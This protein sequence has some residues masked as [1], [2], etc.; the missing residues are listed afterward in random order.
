MN[1]RPFA[2]G[3]VLVLLQAIAHA[4][5]PSSVDP[6]RVCVT[7]GEISSQ[8][9]KEFLISSSTSRAV[10]KKSNGNFN[11]L[12]FVYLGPTPI[13][14][15]LASGRIARQLGLSLRVRDTC[16]L[17]YVM[18]STEPDAGIEISSKSN[19]GKSTH[20]Q[21][22]VKGYKVIYNSKPGDIAAIRVGESRRLEASMD[23]RVLTVKIDGREV[24]QGDVG[25]E[26]GKTSGYSG[27]RTDNVQMRFRWLTSTPSEAGGD[28]KPWPSAMHCT[29][30]LSRGSAGS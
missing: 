4:Q 12:E 1:F 9:G 14:T 23:G 21:C 11:A 17:I 26:A 22:G 6:G 19:P 3:F 15:P 7:N 28:S 25:A 10:A 2:A 13:E 30:V 8:R 24:W 27:I 18:W 16:N 29:R 20:A 5:A